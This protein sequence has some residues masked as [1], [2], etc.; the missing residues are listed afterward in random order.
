MQEPDGIPDPKETLLIWLRE[1]E[2]GNGNEREWEL[3]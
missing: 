2:L 1:W 3:D